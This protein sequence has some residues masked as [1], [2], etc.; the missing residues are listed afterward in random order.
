MGGKKV[1]KDSQRIEAYGS[2]D[3]LNA[4]LGYTR[5]LNQEVKGTGWKNIELRLKR[6]QN[7]LFD[8]GSEL[9]TPGEVFVQGMPGVTPAQ[10]KRLEDEMDLLQKELTT[11][12]SF[13]LPGGGKVSSLL[14]HCRTVCR[15]TE[16][17]VLRLSRLEKINADVLV[18]L[19][20]LSDWFFVVSRW[21]S[22]RKKEKEF[23]WEGGLRKP[24]AR[25]KNKKA[26][27]R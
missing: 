22:K 25:Q 27:K 3:E 14:H 21:I 24:P 11:L 2:V 10:I 4:V 8:L 1:P 16:R 20:R 12:K 15:R 7:E 18:Y 19:N 9:A 17:E 6:I 5:A 26:A 23:L 13:I